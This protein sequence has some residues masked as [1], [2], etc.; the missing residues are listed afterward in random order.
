MTD[1]GY[2]FYMKQDK[3]ELIDMIE[4]AEGNAETY[5]MLVK[6]LRGRI[7]EAIEYIKSEKVITEG[8]TLEQIT[9]YENNL[10]EILGDGNNE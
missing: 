5:E 7:E 10:L 4:N 2:E 3:E 8:H 1:R 9:N 6:E